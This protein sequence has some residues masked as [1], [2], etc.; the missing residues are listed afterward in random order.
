MSEYEEDKFME[1]IERKGQK[2]YRHEFISRMNRK[3]DRKEHFGR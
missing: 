3:L 1:Q 2:Q